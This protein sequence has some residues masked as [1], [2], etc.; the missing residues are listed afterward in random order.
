[1]TDSQHESNMTDSQSNNPNNKLWTYF[2]FINIGA[3]IIQLLYTY[4]FFYREGGLYYYD[5]FFDYL[6]ESGPLFTR[7]LSEVNFLNNI[8]IISMIYN[9]IQYTI[10]NIFGSYLALHIFNILVGLGVNYLIA[11]W[12][13]GGINNK[14]SNFTIANIIKNSFKIASNHAGSIFGATLLLVLTIWIPYINVGAMIGYCAFI[15]ALSKGE[16]IPLA[17]SIFDRKYRKHI[18]EF[19]LLAGFMMLAVFVGYM[20]FIIPGLIIAYAC[21]LAPYI[22]VDK[23]STP[24]ESIKLSNKILY[25]EKLTIFIAHIIMALIYFIT[26]SL[27]MSLSFLSGYEPLVSFVLILL[28]ILVALIYIFVLV[29]S[30]VYIYQEL[31]PKLTE[32]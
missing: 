24:L 8:P 13:V 27:I 9:E 1:M 3:I 7:I 19:C 21:L 10:I 5:S 12:A 15:V 31:S 25:G 11:K 26:V 30:Y 16:N 17:T 23:K 18:V 29:S 4:F 32:E 22:F 2:M 14:S 28:I 20:F 6:R